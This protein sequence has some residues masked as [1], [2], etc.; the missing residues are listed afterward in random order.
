MNT[1]LVINLRYERV[2]NILSLYSHDLDG[3]SCAKIPVD[4]SH[5]TF[6]RNLIF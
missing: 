6:H 1:A 2:N 3:S 4:I 5:T